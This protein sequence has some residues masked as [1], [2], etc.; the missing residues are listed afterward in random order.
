[1]VSKAEQML[2]DLAMTVRYYETHVHEDL[3][4]EELHEVA[5]RILATL[6]VVRR[7]QKDRSDSGVG[8]L[9]S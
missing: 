8:Q 1:M 6:A 9:V 5:E 3:D 7:Y 2:S 4:L